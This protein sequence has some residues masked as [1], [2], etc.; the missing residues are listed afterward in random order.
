MNCV[1]KVNSS[2]KLG[3]G[4]FIRCFNLGQALRNKDFDVTFIY[5]TLMHQHEEMLKLNYFKYHKISNLGDFA[6][7]ES[8]NILYSISIL[9]YSSIDWFVLDD[10]ESDANWD[11]NI[12]S[13]CRNLLVIEDL[14]QHQRACHLLLDMNYRT[15]E[16]KKRISALYESTETLIG[17]MFA[18]LDNRYAKLH[19]SQPSEMEVRTHEILIYFGSQDLNSLTIESLS[20][21]RERFPSIHC[22]VVLLSN[23]PDLETVSEFVRENSGQ[24]QLFVDPEFL[25]E[26]MEECTIS[27]GAGGISLWERMSLNLYCIAVATAENQVS[28][29]QELAA[30]GLITY[31]GLAENFSNLALYQALSAVVDDE[32]EYGKYLEKNRSISDGRGCE[33]VVELMLKGA[34]R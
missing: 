15:E 30:D 33:R 9:G 6:K 14:H 7:P 13:I 26:I 3:S 8:R 17:P 18:L 5:N 20:V 22:K 34:D 29:L 2:E 10:Y 32:S 28:P 23:N 4:H 12:L 16:S 24:F 27:I 25:G 19:S 1:I 21:L 31:L 11:P